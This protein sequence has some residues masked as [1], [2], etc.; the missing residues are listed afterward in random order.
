[1]QRPLPRHQV[2]V[3]VVVKLVDVLDVKQCEVVVT[4]KGGASRPPAGGKG[5]GD[6]GVIIN[7]GFEGGAT[8]GADGVATREG[9]HFVGG[10]AHGGEH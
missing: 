9:D 5:R 10:K 7:P 2:L 6:V 3:L 4:A 1:M 8:G